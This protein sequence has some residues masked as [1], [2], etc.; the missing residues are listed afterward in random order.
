VNG[1]PEE[2]GQDGDDCD[3]QEKSKEQTG[4]EPTPQDD[5]GRRIWGDHELL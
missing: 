4:S 2:I 5:A 3:S 1:D